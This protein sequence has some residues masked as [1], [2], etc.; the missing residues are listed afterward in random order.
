M[1]TA[2]D[3]VIRRGGRVVIDHVELTARGGRVVGIVG[4]NGAGKTTLVE[5]LHGALRADEGRVVV[6]GLDLRSMTRRGIARSIAVVNQDRDA[7][8]PLSVREVV[9]L[10]RLAHRSLVAYGDDADRILVDRALDRV[11]LTALADRLIT[12]VSGGERQRAL[13]AR[14]IVQDADHLLLDEPTNHLDL[15]HQFA[16]LHLVRGIAA[17]TVVVLHDLNLAAS[18]CDDLIL[19]D[20]GR[21]VA[22]GPTDDV[23]DPEL[24][25]GV[26]RV[27]VHR[28]DVA[29]RAR[30]FFDALDEEPPGFPTT[31]SG[32]T[33]GRPSRTMGE[34]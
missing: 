26:Y 20:R 9:T 22:S 16:L 13:I 4:P 33:G 6:D 8:L 7:V 29:G 17:T 30:L 14:A 34:R 21:V 19:L 1:L 15:Q 3:V 18:L 5:A 25:T 11:D 23:L 28:V 32:P 27:R 10:G 31:T 24:L 12:Q 2:E